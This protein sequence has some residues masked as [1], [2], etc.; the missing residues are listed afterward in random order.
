MDGVGIQPIPH[1]WWGAELLAKLF[2]LSEPQSHYLISGN[3]S[4]HVGFEEP[5]RALQAYGEG[6]ARGVGDDFLGPGKEG[7]MD[8]G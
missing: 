8:T 2:G 4:A 7:G 6:L 3:P 5:D 1:A